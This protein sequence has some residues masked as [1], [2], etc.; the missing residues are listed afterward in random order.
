MITCKDCARALNPYLDRELSDEDVVQ[1]RQHLDDCGGCFHL[2]NFQASVRRLVRVRCL[3][4]IAPES[5]RASI[6][7]RFSQERDRPKKRP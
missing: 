3:E 1:V 7:A 2:F 4:Q 5:L 6:I